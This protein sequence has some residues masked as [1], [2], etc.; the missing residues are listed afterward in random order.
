MAEISSEMNLSENKILYKQVVLPFALAASVLLFVFTCILYAFGES[1]L[2]NQFLGG[3]RDADLLLLLVVVTLMLV[4]FNF[5]AKQ[6][7]LYWDAF[8]AAFVCYLIALLL[9]LIFTWVWISIDKNLLTTYTNDAIS[10]VKNHE[11]EFIE[12]VGKDNFYKTIV[13]LQHIS[14]ND[15][16]LDQLIKKGAA[17]IFIAAFLAVLFRLAGFISYRASKTPA[18]S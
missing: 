16:F 3:W 5:A 15:F 6:T 13:S 10:F 11:K 14:P 1:P 12:K 8:L 18:Q 2:G 4:R 9:Y 17:G 7:P